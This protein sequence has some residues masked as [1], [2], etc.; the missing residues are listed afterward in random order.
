VASVNQVILIGR[1]GKD[2]EL[3]HTTG[4]TATCS[5]SLA[6]TDRYTSQGEQKERTEW[7]TIVVW[8]KLAENVQKYVRKGS[9]V[10]IEGRLSY[11]SWEKDGQ[12]RTATDVVANNVQFL[13]KRGD[14]GGQSGAPN[15]NSE[16]FPEM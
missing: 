6:T 13:D 2:P 3:R 4:G 12:K 14:D 9:L 15:S 5:F 11:R 10:Y 1:V 7:H 16:P 8:S